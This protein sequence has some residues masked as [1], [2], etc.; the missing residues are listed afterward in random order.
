[1]PNKYCYICGRINNQISLH[2][3]PKDE[4]L[5]RFWLES[6]DLNEADKVD[7]LKLCFKH[8]TPEDFINIKARSFGGHLTLNKNA[9]PSVDVPTKVVKPSPSTFTDEEIFKNT[10]TIKEE[11]ILQENE[12]N[13][14]SS[15]VTI[16]NIMMANNEQNSKNIQ[17][18]S[19]KKRKF[20]EARFVSEIEDADLEKPE[21]ARRAI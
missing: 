17:E 18:S 10:T 14:I 6:C 13:S 2:K 9:V 12:N 5:K 8:F 16:D 7:T 4:N 3:F 21:I 20:F 19:P 1:M 15:D 11:I